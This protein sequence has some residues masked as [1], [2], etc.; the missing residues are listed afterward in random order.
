M[1]NKPNPNWVEASLEIRGWNS[2]D[3]EFIKREIGKREEDGNI[4]ITML[5]EAQSGKFIRMETISCPKIFKPE[6]CSC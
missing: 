4:L 2:K 6:D 5:V 1:K 3:G